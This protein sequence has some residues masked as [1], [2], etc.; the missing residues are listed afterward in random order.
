VSDGGENE[1]LATKSLAKTVRWRCLICLIPVC[2]ALRPV[3]DL[4]PNSLAEPLV[5]KMFWAH[6]VCPKTR[7]AALGVPAKGRVAAI[8]DALL[9]CRARTEPGSRGYARIGTS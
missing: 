6:L 1:E 8:T 4:A 9:D 3:L 2:P 5:T 7:K